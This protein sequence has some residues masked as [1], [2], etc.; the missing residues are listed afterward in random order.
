MKANIIRIG[1]SKGIRLPKPVLKQCGLEESVE[2]E[3]EGNRLV[4]RPVCRARSSWAKA[5]T[6][7][8]Q[9]KDDTLL[10][11]ETPAATAWDK[12]EWRW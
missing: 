10:D 5:F 1:N 7:M 11:R 12:T 8:A 4:I 6:E 9:R 2:I 3:V